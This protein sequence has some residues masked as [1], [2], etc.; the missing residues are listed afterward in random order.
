VLSDQVVKS[1]RRQRFLSAL[2]AGL[3]YLVVL[4]IL[5]FYFRYTVKE[6]NFF[7]KKV[8]TELEGHNGPVIWA[9]NHLTMLDSF[10]I[11]WAATPWRKA[12][13]G[14]EIPW[15]TPEIE[16]Y[17]YLGGWVKKNLIRMLMYFCR[18]I[19]ISRAGDGEEA[20]EGRQAV[21]DKCAWILKNGGPVFVFPEATRSRRGWFNRHKPKDFL[22]RL[23]LEAPAAKFFCVYLRG[24]RQLYSTPAPTRGEAFRMEFAVLPAV[25]EGESS[26]RQISTRLFNVL[27]DLQ[28]LWFKE[29]K[30]SR[31]C[32]GNDV[33]DLQSATAL[34][35]FLDDTEDDSEWVRRHLT[36][37]EWVYWQAQS[38]ENR[39]SI[40]WKFFAAKEAASKAIERSDVFVPLGAFR[41]FE[42]D[43]FQNIVTHRPTGA[44]I[45]VA[46]THEDKDKLHC[47]AVL[48]GGIVG[49]EGSPGDVLWNVE[50]VPAGADPHEFA[51]E[52]CLS[53][54][55]ESSDDIFSPASLALSDNKG[56]PI[57]LKNG[58]P[59]DISVS[60]SHSGRYVAYSFLVS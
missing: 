23:A 47:I 6:I 13:R 32:S 5:R 40:F 51:R 3:V 22:G 2:S 45:E 48:R 46:F 30:M 14:S 55:A 58:R 9:A 10:L 29:A 18:C 33:I 52:C 26:P 16:N 20:Q 19:P 27:G 25:I 21:F 50:E 12:I 39:F 7:R 42:V 31:N 35:H 8:Q 56:L 43:L 17:Y 38:P 36:E 44:N 54:I 59:L 4:S 49:S 1:I 11:F 60:L 37:K 15:S 28:D 57:I 41:S 24:E 53:F 34:E